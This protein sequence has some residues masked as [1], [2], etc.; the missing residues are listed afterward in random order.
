[1]DN[2]NKLLEELIL[3]LQKLKWEYSGKNEAVNALCGLF[4]LYNIKVS[5]VL[6]R[7]WLYRQ[8]QLPT[9]VSDL[10]EK[11]VIKLQIQQIEN[12]RNNELF[13]EQKKAVVK[14]SFC[15]LKDIFDDLISRWQEIIE[16][17]EKIIQVK[18]EIRSYNE[19]IQVKYSSSNY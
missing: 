5:E 19:V 14:S 6:A 2:N 17:E 16:L 7:C 9:E 18:E 3:K 8:I 11:E 10:I 1:M 15:G 13:W 12:E 4:S